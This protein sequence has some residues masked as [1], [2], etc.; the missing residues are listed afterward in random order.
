MVEYRNGVWWDGRSQFSGSRFVVEGKFVD[1]DYSSVTE[2]IDLQGAVVLAPFGEGHNHDTAA[3]MFEQANREYLRNGVFYVKNPS[4]FPPAVA[5]IRNELSRVDT[6][7]AS[8]TY[9]A[10]T[11]PGGHPVP[12]Y[13]DFLS[14]VL[15]EGASYAEFRGQAFHEVTT[16]SETTAALDALVAQGADFAKAMLLYSEDFDNGYRMGLD[17]DLLPMLVREAH[18][19]GLSVSLHVESTEDFRRGV[20]AGV[21]EIAHLPGGMIWEQDRKAEEGLLTAEDGEQAAASGVA[22]VTTTRVQV[23]GDDG[24]EPERRAE[25][26]QVQ[27]ENLEF[28]LQA[29]VEIRIGSDTRDTAGMENG[30]NTTRREAEHLVALGVFD[31]AAALARWMHT[32]RSVFPKRQIGCFAAGC[33]ASFLVYEADPRDDL[34]NLDRLVLAIKKG[35]EVHR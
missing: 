12:L 32:G 15:Y 11:S 28:L 4:A 24:I 25:W 1:A 20:E 10:L 31:N 2:V 17:P 26:T 5:A 22:V 27:S 16:E 35:V 8:I 18:K 30:A 19:R 14:E 33:E 29:G 7:D 23:A 21:D 34:A 13:V 9:G 3:P 6:I